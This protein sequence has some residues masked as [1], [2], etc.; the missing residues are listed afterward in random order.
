MF[1]VA[2]FWGGI[3]LGSHFKGPFL[4][5]GFGFAVLG[6]AFL[7]VMPFSGERDASVA[8]GLRAFAVWRYRSP[9]IS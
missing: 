4:G 2:L 8:C 5:S 9:A 7:G 1:G 6:V 3:I